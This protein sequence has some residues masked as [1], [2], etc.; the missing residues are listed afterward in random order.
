MTKILKSLKKIKIPNQEA[1][2]FLFHLSSAKY[3][4][5]SEKQASLPLPKSVINGIKLDY[6]DISKVYSGRTGGRDL[7]LKKCAEFFQRNNIKCSEKNIS[8]IPDIFTGISYAY[9]ILD[10]KSSQLLIPVPT[11]GY[12]FQQFK[13]K[14]INFKMI[15]TRKENNFLLDPQDLKNATKDLKTNGILL[16]CYPNNP[17]GVVMPRENAEEI[18]KIANEEDLFVIS[19]EVFIKSI[20]DPSKKHCSI[21]S[22]EGMIERSLTFFGLTKMMNLSGTE[23]HSLR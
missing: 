14:G 11:F 20:L 22:I 9:D 5:T 21:A 8:M 6:D 1:F 10:A 7:V 12:Y 18:A 3:D 2:D 17:T 15:E 23:C 4:F 19:D 16:L 13:D